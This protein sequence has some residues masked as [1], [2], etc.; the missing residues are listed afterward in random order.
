[1][2]EGHLQ[3]DHDLWYVV[4][5]MRCGWQ[6]DHVKWLEKSKR[7]HTASCGSNQFM[8]APYVPLEIREAH[9]TLAKSRRKGRSSKG[10]KWPKRSKLPS[11]G[12]CITAA[13][14]QFRYLNSPEVYPSDN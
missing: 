10:R 9:S 4:Q 5:C 2:P 12:G 6:A 3:V 14:K 1:M 8:V 13:G 7:R 11:S